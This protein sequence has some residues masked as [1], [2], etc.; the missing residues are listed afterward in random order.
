MSEYEVVVDG[1]VRK[2]ASRWRLIIDDE[3]HGIGRLVD[4]ERSLPVIVEGAG[5]DW[6]VTLHGRRTEVRVRTWRERLLAEAQTSSAVQ[7]GPVVVKATLPGLIVAV[8]VS[9]GHE[10][11]EG[12]TLLTIEAMKMQNEVRSPRAGRVVEV[13][14]ASGQAV[15]TGT[16]LVRIE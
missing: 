3:G 1:T 2:P 12:T 13:T 15:A 14:V 7:A 11:E 5:S 10:V 9:V 8:V 4:G 6:T 16:P